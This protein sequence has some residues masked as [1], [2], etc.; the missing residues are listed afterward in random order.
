M[1]EA[2]RVILCADDYAQAPGIS[3]GILRLA[4]AG[5]LSATSAMVH[6]PGWAMDAR[7]AVGLRDRMSLG[8]HLTLTH[9]APL[10]PMPRLAPG[11]MFPSLGRLM[12][13]ALTGRLMRPEMRAEI[14]AEIAR[15][16]V[17]FEA[18]AG[19]P[20]HVD[21]H[22]HVHVLPGIA[23]PLLAAIRTRYAGRG[24]LLRDPHDRLKA[25]IG[26][27]SA[28]KAAFV[29]TLAT[30]FAARARA[31]GAVTTEGFSGYSDFGPVPYAQEFPRFLKALGPRPMVMCHP[32]LGRD[33][34]DPISARREEEFAYLMDLPGLPDRLW[35]PRRGPSGQI[36][37]GGGGA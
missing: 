6:M 16:L 30:G 11:G 33:A 20:D 8:L 27:G 18:E 32:G 9:G 5:R 14:A 36:D 29:G 25:L 31:A 34:D 12:K 10:G 17:A 19:A 2:P 15:Q 23:G 1:P 21:G 3:E 28:V 4:G 13:L 7:R 37:W 24:V 35:H 22:Q 26:R